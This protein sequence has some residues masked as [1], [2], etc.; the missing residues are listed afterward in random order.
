MLYMCAS[1]PSDALLDRGIWVIPD[2]S[3]Q[4]GCVI[5]YW[6]FSRFLHLALHVMMRWLPCFF[7]VFVGHALR[8]AVVEH[9]HS[10]RHCTVN[11][12]QEKYARHDLQA[13]T[14]PHDLER[15]RRDPWHARFKVFKCS[16]EWRVNLSNPTAGSP[17]VELSSCLFTSSY[18]LFTMLN[19]YKIQ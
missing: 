4:A 7:C 3:K 15:N 12:N 10:S 14:S 6:R 13:R 16:H 5:V 17:S 2:L 11:H 18:P 1:L 19:T 8:L 9:C